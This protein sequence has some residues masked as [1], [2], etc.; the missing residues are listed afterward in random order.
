MYCQ[1]LIL[2]HYFWLDF[3]PM[4]MFQSPRQ[5]R[6]ITCLPWTAPL[7]PSSHCRFSP[8]RGSFLV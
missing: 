5:A 4:S 8:S 7:T 2:M 6:G 1:W 3:P